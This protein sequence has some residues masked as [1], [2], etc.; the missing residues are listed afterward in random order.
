MTACP[1]CPNIYSYL[2][3]FN[4][5]SPINL[6]MAVYTLSEIPNTTSWIREL[7]K[8][9]AESQC[10]A[11]G[12]TPAD[13]LE[14]IRTQL[15]NFAKD[16]NTKASLP[17]NSVS[18]MT[19][20]SSEAS[21]NRDEVFP[22]N[23]N[24]DPTT[25]ALVQA[26]HNTTME[27]ITR[28]TAEMRSHTPKTTEQPKPPQLILD[29][30]SEIPRANGA[31]P[32]Q[33]VSFLA[34]LAKIVSLQIASDKIIISHATARTED[35]L[36]DFWIEGVA[37]GSDWDL[38]LAHFRQNFLTPE[39]LR[40]TKD[41]LL[42]RRQCMGEKLLDFV[43]DIIRLFQILAPETNQTDIYNTIF[44]S[45]NIQTRTSFAGL[46]PVLT[47]ADLLDI[48]PLVDSITNDTATPAPAPATNSLAPAARPNP[49]ANRQWVRQPSANRAL[50][51]QQRTYQPHTSLRPPTPT[52]QYYAN[53]RHQHSQQFNNRGNH[54]NYY[55]GS[56]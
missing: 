24:L 43:N 44:R 49:P 54:L 37:K 1:P 28:L 8:Q 14:G 18:T 52:H 2:F 45:I 40:Q 15:R 16:R 36:R 50:P 5:N 30:I 27:A 41:Q 9:D 55:R 12:L 42:Y 31:D 4:S 10:L 39:A 22:P 46:K 32:I 53:P 19:E 25:A 38:L 11:W 17:T 56:Q 35:R 20:L 26:M 47:V 3:V 13:T 23:P 6:I 34:K 21:T 29:L 7:N 48:A 33:T 51:W